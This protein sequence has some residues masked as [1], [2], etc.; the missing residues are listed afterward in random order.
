M[1]INGM[2]KV[3]VSLACIADNPDVRLLPARDLDAERI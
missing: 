1:W 2:N 3:I